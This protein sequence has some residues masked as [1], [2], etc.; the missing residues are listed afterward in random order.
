[1]MLLS[2]LDGVW[3][4]NNKSS[5]AWWMWEVTGP[6]CLLNVAGAKATFHPLTGKVSEG[7]WNR[8]GSHPSFRTSDR[9]GPIDPTQMAMLNTCRKLRTIET[10][11]Y[12]KGNSKY[13]PRKKSTCK[14]E[15]QLNQYIQHDIWSHSMRL[16]STAKILISYAQE[17][18]RAKPL[19]YHW[20]WK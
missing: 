17:A 13:R 16:Q 4:V 2:P 7:G 19:S 20:S 9:W 6:F 14:L 15:I 1:M 8:I 3:R 5:L 18:M 12:R 11:Q 10:T